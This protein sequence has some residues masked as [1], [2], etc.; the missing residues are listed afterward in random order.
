MAE[1]RV[2]VEWRFVVPP[3]NTTRVVIMQRTDGPFAKDAVGRAGHYYVSVETNEGKGWRHVKGSSSGG[4]MNQ[5]IAVEA[6]EE[7]WNQLRGRK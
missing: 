1:H 4:H 2:S 5:D 7:V 6:A 3:Q